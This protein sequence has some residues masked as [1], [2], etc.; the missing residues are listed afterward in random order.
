MASLIGELLFA[1]IRGLAADWA[2]ALFV[3]LAA[4]LD[5]KIHGRA[6]KVVVGLLLG[7]AAFILIPVFSGL[8]G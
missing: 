8:L 2:Y 5:P 6:A 4:W 3:K 1:I 7:L